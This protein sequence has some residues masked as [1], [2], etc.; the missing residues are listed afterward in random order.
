MNS[1]VFAEARS[2][3]LPLA[4]KDQARLCDVLASVH[5]IDAAAAAA[6]DHLAATFP[7]S[8]RSEHAWLYCRAAQTLAFAG[9][10]DLML[11]G[12]TIREEPAARSFYTERGWDF[13]DVE[14]TFLYRFAS[15]RPGSFPAEMG[16]D[17][18]HMLR[19]SFWN[20]R[21][22]SKKQV[23]ATPRSPAPTSS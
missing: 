8:L 18:P 20:V 19:D 16:P 5:A 21:G 14:Y 15:Q 6:Y 2:I 17:Y 4:A 11:L 22:N 3:G 1:K 10:S 9:Q 12:R 7:D 23:T 13:D